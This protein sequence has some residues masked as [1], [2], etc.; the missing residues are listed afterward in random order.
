[1]KSIVVTEPHAPLE[2]VDRKIPEP[3][4]AGEEVIRV[5]A[6]G[7]CHSDLHVADG[8]F[9]G[10]YPVVLGHEVVGEHHELG[11]VLLYAPWGCGKPECRQ[12]SAG[13]EMIC[14]NGREAGIVS[15]GG[16]SEYMRVP[17][18]EY[19]VPIG[20]LDPASTAPLACGGLTAFRAVKRVLAHLQAKNSRA[21]VIGAGGLGQFAIQFLKTLTNAELTVVDTSPEKL[22]AA[23]SLGADV[24]C[25]VD[26]LTGKYDAVIDF[27]GADATMAASAFVIDRQGIIVVVGLWGG[28]I[29]FGVGVLPSEAVLTTSIWGS[30]D[31]LK[32]LLEFARNHPLQHSVETIPLDQAQ[33]A[34]DR[35]RAGSIKGR[36]VLVTD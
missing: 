25:G 36:A 31:E 11:R 2:L 9:G 10:P 34:H 29:E 6:C 30:L 27:V 15:D 14:P 13:L 32:E 28:R 17:K 26:G 8:H 21:I 20:D 5:L 3:L 33:H 19:L 35:L 7:V 4:A 22:D 24:T 1:M 16:Y 12:C 18:R 23:T